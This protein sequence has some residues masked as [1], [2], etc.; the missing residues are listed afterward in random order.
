[1]FDPL[2]TASGFGVGALVGLTG[3][4]GGSLMTPLLILLFGV[5]PATAVGTDLLFAASTKS[6][7]AVIHARRQSIDWRATGLLAAGSVPASAMTL[8]MLGVLDL[9]AEAAAHAITPILAVALLATAVMLIFQRQVV[10]LLAAT[11]AALRPGQ[12]AALNIAAGVLLG[13][14]V[15]LSSV[16]AGSLG[17]TMLALL[18]PRLPTHRIVGSDIAHAIPLTLIAG[19][20]YW[21]MGAVDWDLLGTLLVGSVPGIVLGSLLAGRIPGAALRYLLAVVLVLVVIKLLA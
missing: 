14:L 8:L 17:V 6:V 5:H 3:V 20:G 9:R 11:T 10:T 2:Y 15:S 13:I 4:G 18:Y 19:C 1:M 12:V 16:G 7:G 21:I